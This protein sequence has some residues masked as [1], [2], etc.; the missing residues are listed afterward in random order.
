MTDYQRV[1]DEIRAF[2]QGT[3]QTLTDGLKEL[4]SLYGDACREVNQRLRRCE[5]YLKKGL[6]GEAIHYAEAEPVLLDVVAVLDFPERSDFHETL[7]FY[8]LP[9][10]PQLLLKIAKDLNQAYAEEQP[11]EELLPRH[12]RLALLRA[13]VLERL[14]VLRQIAELDQDNPLWGEDVRLFE[15][16]ASARNPDSDGGPIQGRCRPGRRVCPRA[17]QGRLAHPPPRSPGCAGG[18][19]GCLPG[20]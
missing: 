17:F 20:P 6:R 5:E 10:P 9:E 19:A 14:Q 11:L 16:A 4:A 8:A 2:L 13:P 12:R 15:G 18:Q 7:I 3:D 1:V